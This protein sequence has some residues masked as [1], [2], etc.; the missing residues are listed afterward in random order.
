VFNLEVSKDHSYVANG[1]AV[2]N[3]RAC[4]AQHGRTFP[5]EEPGPID[6]HQGRCAR[7]PVTKS[8]TELGFPGIEEPAPLIQSAVDEFDALTDQEQRSILGKDYEAWK[9]GDYPIDSWVTTRS[10]PGWRDSIAPTT[11]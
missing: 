5:L 2:H 1:Y 11:A 9:A 8:W 4:I 10:N 6:H 3:C 7:A